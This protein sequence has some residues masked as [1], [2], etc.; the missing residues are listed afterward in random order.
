M[1]TPLL[2]ISDAPTSGTGFGRITRDLSTRIAAHMPDV[3]R[4]A[5]LG[6]GGSYSRSLPFAQYSI[7]MNDWVILNLPEVWDD[8]AED[9]PGIIMT[10]WDASRL[11]W[12]AR[13]E[14][15][16]DKRLQ[17]FLQ[18]AKFKRWGYFPIDAT[19]PHD[20]LTVVLKHIL[21]GYDRIL[22]YSAWA[23]EIVD[24][25]F[26]KVFCEHRPHGIDTSVF[27]PRNRHAARHGFGERIGARSSKGKFFSIPDDSLAIGIVATNQVRKDWGLGIETVAEIKKVRKVLL[28]CHTDALERHWSLPALLSDFGGFDDSNTAISTIELTDEQMAFCYSAMDVTLAIGLGEGFGFGAA[29]SLACGVPAVAPNYGGGEFIPKY[30]LVDPVATR[31]E[32]PYNCIRPV[33]DYSDFASTAMAVVGKKPKC[34]QYID[35][36]NLWPRWEEWLRKGVV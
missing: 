33:M 9:E 34:P 31:I 28:W 23:A 7:E 22:A 5:T 20:K 10:I 35:W 16:T 6:Y 19:G 18:T 12:F 3:F 26:G 25:T 8:F 13:P 29:E 1:P 36:T 27:Y 21:E 17:K 2:I 24:R 4:V 14:N 32:G 11:L 15:C 30:F